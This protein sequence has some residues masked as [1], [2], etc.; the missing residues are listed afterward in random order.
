[1][2]EPV[3]LTTSTMLMISLATTAA[4]T[5]A[6]F[7]AQ[8]AA[9]D[10]QNAQREQTRQNAISAYETQIRQAV[11]QEDQQN[12]ATALRLTDA[13]IKGAKAEASAL[14]AAGESGVGGNA[15]ANIINDYNAQE[16][17][18]ESSVVQQAG[19]DTINRQFQLEGLQQQAIGRVQ[20]A[21]PLAGP[22]PGLALLSFG[23]DAA[24]SYFKYNQ[25]EGGS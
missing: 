8:S 17:R 25:T 10:Q 21:A 15:I 6:S 24:S 12:Q 5:A 23:T 19:F 1:M 4:S 16:A 11:V 13:K 18:Y 14:T 9:V 2:C 22:S 7:V 3:T 20:S